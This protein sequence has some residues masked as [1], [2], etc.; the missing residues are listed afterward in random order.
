MMFQKRGSAPILVIQATAVNVTKPAAIT[1]PTK[2]VSPAAPYE[3][4]WCSGLASGGPT[5]R[6]PQLGQPLLSCPST[7]E[8]QA[9]QM[10]KIANL[11]KVRELN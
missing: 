11:K 5:A 9:G 10:I 3:T 2:P 7:V 1:P 4:S 6:A 8:P